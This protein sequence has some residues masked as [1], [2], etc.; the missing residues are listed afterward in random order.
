MEIDKTKK[1]KKLERYFIRPI[2]EPVLGLTITKDTDVEDEE[3][4]ENETTKILV[5]QKIKG[6]K[7]ITEK[8][9][10]TTLNNDVPMTETSRVELDLP[11]GT[12][13][14]WLEGKGYILPNEPFVTM[15]EIEE[16]VKNLLDLDLGE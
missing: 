8:T 16:D 4:K 15:H 1:Q 3:V 2:W 13:L 6:T 14:V 10:T 5:Q 9:M 7:F 12:R 11:E